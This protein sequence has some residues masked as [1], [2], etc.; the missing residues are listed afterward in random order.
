MRSRFML[1]AI[2]VL[3]AAGAACTSGRHSAAAFRL[4]PD[5]GAVKGQAA[6]VA[7]GCNTCHEVTGADLPRPTVQ[8][9]V[10]VVLTNPK[11]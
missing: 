9:A 5:G 11:T 3:A 7:L 2:A 8:P 4:P 10:P 6:F 1:L